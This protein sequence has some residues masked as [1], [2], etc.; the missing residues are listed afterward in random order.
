MLS[1]PS[2]LGLFVPEAK[3]I[4]GPLSSSLTS[5]GRALS[6]FFFVLFCPFFLFSP[7]QAHTFIFDSTVIWAS[8]CH[9]NFTHRVERW[10]ICIQ[11]WQLWLECHKG[12]LVSLFFYFLFYFL[13]WQA[14]ERMGEKTIS[15]FLSIFSLSLSLSCTHRHT[16]IHRKYESNIHEVGWGS[17]T[18]ICFLVE[19]ACSGQRHPSSLY[20]T[21][22]CDREHMTTLLRH[23]SPQPRRWS[24]NR[25]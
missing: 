12:S 11:D 25:S 15:P 1:C 24:P 17:R 21:A 3:L 2:T 7:P 9:F 6:T 22:E 16:Q 18:H 23:L 8:F 10:E 19:A 14:K 4:T 13:Q 5:C 20:D